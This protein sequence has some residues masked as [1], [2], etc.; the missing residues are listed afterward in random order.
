MSLSLPEANCRLA[1]DLNNKLAIVLG[2]C[3]LLMEISPTAPDYVPRLQAIHNAARSMAEALKKH[4]CEL[5]N[6][7]RQPTRV[8]QPRH[9]ERVPAS[10]S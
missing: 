1:H 5:S 6:L 7:L 9:P 10:Q 2:Y 3:E 4:Q 8:R